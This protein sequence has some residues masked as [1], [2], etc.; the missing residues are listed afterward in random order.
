MLD[1]VHDQHPVRQTGEGIV[2]DLV[3]EPQLRCLPVADVTSDAVH[4]DDFAVRVTHGVE[5]L[6]D[7]DLGAVLAHELEIDGAP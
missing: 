4:S 5:A 2:K 7:P 3:L 6:V 1:P